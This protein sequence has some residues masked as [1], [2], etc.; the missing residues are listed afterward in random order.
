MTQEED[1]LTTDLD[2]S[3]L[4]SLRRDDTEISVVTY[5]RLFGYY[6][7]DSN[8]FSTCTSTRI[9][10]ATSLDSGNVYRFAN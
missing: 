3:I 1:K 9:S 6:L 7:E 5:L 8:F 4:R 2:C 10:E